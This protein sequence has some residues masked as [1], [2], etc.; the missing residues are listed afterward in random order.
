MG[1]KKDSGGSKKK[2]GGFFKF[3]VIL[4]ILAVVGYAAVKILFPAEKVRAEIVSRASK[5]LGRTVELDEV[6]ISIIPGPRLDLKGLRIFNPEGFPGGDFVSVDRL[7]C[8]LKIMPLLQKRFVF[9]EIKVEHPVIH[10]RKA[11][12]GRTNYSFKV[13]TKETGLETPPGT[14]DTVSSG[15][16]A[17]SVIAFD[18]ASIQNG[19]LSFVDDSAQSQ[20]TVS[21]FS[22]ETKLNLDAT[23]KKG[24]SVGTFKMP[25]ITASAMPNKIP[26]A[27]ELTYNADVDFQQGDFLFSNTTLKINGIPF[28]VDAT[29]RNAFGPQSIYAK[30][31]ASGVSLEPLLSYIPS[32]PNFNASQLRL[33][34]TLDGEVEARIEIGTKLAPSFGGWLTFNN[35]TAGYQTVAARLHFGSLQLKF[36]ADT[37]AFLTEGATVSDEPFSLAGSVR[38]WKDLMFDVKTK[39]KLN[40][41]AIVPFLDSAAHHDLSGTLAFDLQLL[42]RKSTWAQSTLLGRIAVDKLHYSSK[43]LTKPL[44]RLDLILSFAANKA[45]VD[46]LYAEYPGV[47]ASLTGTLNNGLAHLLQPHKDFPRPVL[48]FA[49]HA[50]LV[51]YDVLFPEEER[52]KGAAGQLPDSIP[53]LFIP[54]VEAHGS[55]LV[56]TFVYSKVEFTHMSGDITYKDKL[57]TFKNAK[58]NLYTGNVAGDGSVEISNLFQPLVK[59]QFSGTN[60][61]ANDFLERFANLG[62]HLYG[63]FDMQ[64]NLT[65]QGSE[66]PDFVRTLTAD[67]KVNMKEGRLVNF[68]LINQM[69][70]KFGFKTFQE[71]SI[72]DFASVIKIRDGKLLFDGTKLISKM[73]DWNVGG[74]VGFVDKS[75]NLD[76]GVYL[77]QD[78]AKQLSALGSLFQDDKG[79]VKIN[80]AIGGSYTSPNI[81]NISTDKNVVKQKAADAIKKGADNLLNGLLKKK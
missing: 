53:P 46:S 28:L 13:T 73:G 43:K 9:T 41:S 6:S 33:S 10:L 79:R 69:A 52:A 14:P 47:R 2:G 20:L 50:P 34:G 70:G 19:D 31:K 55:A 72:R 61:E 66:V 48:D 71:E 40:L 26:L 30:I 4:V 5:A 60:I 51:N 77:T 15:E 68:D 81:S 12:D 38:N 35:T 8:D 17:M 11:A 74:T 7:A 57:I 59:A 49:L 64:G 54:D 42:G 75:L 65:G 67:G 56:D 27:V 44:Q 39:G 18:W 36:T 80:F 29:I 32:F 24:K 3:V 16:A 78:V 45:S 21:D 76:M 58:A 1:E 23:G 63:K 25:S 22:L 37:A 62:G